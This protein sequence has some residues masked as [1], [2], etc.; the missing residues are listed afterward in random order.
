MET[1][2]TTT[3]KIKTSPETSYDNRLS[4]NA[5]SRWFIF[6]R[7]VQKLSPRPPFIG[8]TAASGASSQSVGVNGTHPSG[9][10]SH[11]RGIAPH[12]HQ[13]RKTELIN[14]TP[15]HQLQKQPLKDEG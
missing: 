15:K 4:L 13:Q 12:P 3:R 5:R 11:N 6:I 8:G 7:R 9:I 1:G 14:P 2:G 10:T